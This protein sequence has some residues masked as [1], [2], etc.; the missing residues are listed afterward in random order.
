MTMVLPSTSQ[1]NTISTPR[2][3]SN[4]YWPGISGL[5]TRYFRLCVICQK[6]APR[7]R[8]AKVP[9]GE[10]LLIDN[11]FNVLL[12]IWLDQSFQWPTTR[13]DTHGSGLRKS[14]SRSYSFAQ[15]KDGNGSKC[16]AECFLQS[17]ICKRYWVT[18]VHSLQPT[19]WDKFAWECL[20]SKSRQH[21]TIQDATDLMN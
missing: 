2:I 21:R 17:W 9:L 6:T 8:A 14:L 16:V 13:T 18:V 11:R 20:S 4:W 7:S 15:D 10:M 5:V 19:R 12:W 3:M 1:F